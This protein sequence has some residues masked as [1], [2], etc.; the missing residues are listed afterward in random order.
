MLQASLGRLSQDLFFTSLGA[1]HTNRLP[2]DFKP[3]FPQEISNVT[4]HLLALNT[5]FLKNQV[6]H[7]TDYFKIFL[8]QFTNFQLYEW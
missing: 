1:S 6:R 3:C 8:L 2:S 4:Y 7:Q 5:L